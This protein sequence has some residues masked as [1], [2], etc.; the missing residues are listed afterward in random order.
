MRRTGNCMASDSIGV[1]PG[2][3][4]TFLDHLIPIC[5][6]MEIPVHCS[7]EWVATCASQFYPEIKIASG[8]LSAY[9]TFYVVEPC[10]LHGKAVQFGSHVQNGDFKTVAGFHG[11]PDKFR[12]IFWIERYLDEDVILVYG[13]HLI[14]YLKEKGIFE[15][16]KKTVRIGN[17]R[18]VFYKQHQNFFDTVARP[19]L[20]PAKNRRTV[21]WAPTWSFSHSADDSP[22]FDIYS[23]VLNQIPE[24][25]QLYV[26]LHPYMYR[27]FPEKVARIKEEYGQARFI[28]EIPLVYPFLNQIDIYLGDYSSIVYDFLIFNRPIFFLGEKREEWGTTVND[29]KRLFQELDRPD[30][31]A[32]ERQKVY[33]YVFGEEVSMKEIKNQ[34]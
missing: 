12:E 19:H 18:F 30:K 31:L 20:F 17:F 28:D 16:L 34:L 14:D 3:R 5:H 6:L 23:Q 10:K 22:F 24:E 2:P 15:R 11:N 25:Y 9:K 8:D 29:P 13:Q 7:D 33:E 4:T 27:L 1:V 32:P 26:K 21:L